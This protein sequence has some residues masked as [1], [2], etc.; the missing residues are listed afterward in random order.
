MKGNVVKEFS[1]KK[2]RAMYPTGI[3]FK[4]TFH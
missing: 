4:R 2:F 1:Q 3:I